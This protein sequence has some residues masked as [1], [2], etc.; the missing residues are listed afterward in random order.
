MSRLFNFLCSK[1]SLKFVDVNIKKE[2]RILDLELDEVEISDRKNIVFLY[3]DNSLEAIK[4]LLSFI[5]SKHA[6]CLL[7]PKLNLEFKNNLELCYSPLYVYD[8]SRTE[9]NGFTNEIINAQKIFKSEIKNKLLIHSDIKILLSTSGTTGSPKLVKLSEENLISNAESITDYLPISSTDVVPLNLPIYYSYGLSILTSNCSKGSTILCTNRT[10]LEKEFWGDFENY[11]CTS[12]AGVPY[13]YEMLKRIGFFKKS[14]ASLKYMTQ[15]GG[16]LTTNL[17]KDY[18][19]WSRQNNVKFYVMYGQTEATAR[20][21][22]L[23][24]VDLNH[25]LGSIGKAIPN[26]TLKISD[27]NSELLY[28]GPNVFGGYASS[29]E[30]LSSFD[31]PE[32][33]YTGDL[34]EMDAAGYIYIVGRLKRFIKLV[35]KRINIDEIENFIK[36][37]FKLDGIS[38]FGLSDKKI[39]ISHLN[40][41]DTKQIKDKIRSKFDIHPTAIDFNKVEEIPTNSNGKIDF[42]KLEI[43]YLNRN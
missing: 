2:Y 27:V 35:G 12:L 18:F 29:P 9:L 40:A 20:M 30:E 1:S 22:Y 24:Y 15:A 16:K 37:E 13:L 38:L 32:W 41:I 11:K 4:V 34:A 5:K 8:I 36:N 33:L 3:L 26:G 10:V 42:R 21:S 23:D 31:Q 28:N 7:D 25:K 19:N 6:L 43:N 14:Y 17:T 39:I